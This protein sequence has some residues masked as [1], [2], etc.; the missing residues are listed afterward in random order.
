MSQP[1]QVPQNT[2]AF[3]GTAMLFLAITAV[4][5][6]VNIWLLDVSVLQRWTMAM[7][8]LSAMFAVVV[9]SKVVRD[10]E[11]AARWR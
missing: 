3:F 5:N 2:A 8:I 11:E 10:R 4:W 7:S 6:V 9:V 1:S